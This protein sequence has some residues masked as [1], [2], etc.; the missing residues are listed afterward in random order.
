MNI[1]RI[2]IW[3]KHLEAMRDFYQKYFKGER[4]EKYLNPINQFES[5]FMRFET[6]TKLELMRRQS[7]DKPSDSEG[8]LGI[9]HIA[10]KLGSEKVV[11]S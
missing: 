7:V 5:Y 3:T 10:F 11:R 9:N 1:A 4:N 2:A 6:G 8:R